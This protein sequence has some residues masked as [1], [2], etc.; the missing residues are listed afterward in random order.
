MRST[1]VLCSLALLGGSAAFAQTAASAAPA[2]DGTAAPT[3]LVHTPLP[4]SGALATAPG[5]WRAANQAVAE[6]PRGHADIVAWEARQAAPAKQAP[7]HG[8]NHP[9]HQHGGQP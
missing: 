7:A 6:F 9:H 5:D 4:A 1:H 8:Q 3:P 2:A